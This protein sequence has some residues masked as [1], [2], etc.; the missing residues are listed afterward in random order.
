MTNVPYVGKTIELRDQLIKTLKSAEFRLQ[1]WTSN[2]TE[3]RNG[4][5]SEDVVNF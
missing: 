4:I 3:V 5:S 1:K 2:C